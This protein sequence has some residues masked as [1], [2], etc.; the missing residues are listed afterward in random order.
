MLSRENNKHRALRPADIKGMKSKDGSVRQ[1]TLARGFVDKQDGH[2]AKI[3][4]IGV[5]GGS[6]NP[7]EIDVEFFRNAL[8]YR[9]NHHNSRV[10]LA[11]V[12]ISENKYNTA[13]KHAVLAQSENP[14]TENAIKY[15]K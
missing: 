9:R 11:S 5:Q 3:Q 13:W 15:A 1:V 4:V 12:K 2:T 7:T 14:K 8:E 6:I 10:G